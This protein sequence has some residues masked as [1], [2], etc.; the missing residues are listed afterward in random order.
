[1]S[2]LPFEKFSQ[3]IVIKKES[4]TSNEYGFNY[5]ERPLRK[6]LDYS[7]VVINK[8]KGPS[9]HQISDYLKKILNA[10]KAGHSGTLDPGVTGCLPIT[11]N[12]ATRIVQTL[13][14]SGKEYI[15]LMHLHNKIPQSKIHQ[16]FKKQ[17]GKIQQVPPIKS[18]VKRV[19]RTREI[20][21]IEI[22]EIENQEV[23]F[24]VGCEAGT[25]IRKLCHDIGQELKTG[26]HMAQLVRTKAGPFNF[27]NSHS[28]Y[29]IKD[30]FESKNESE[31]R[32]FLL[33]F[34][35][36]VKYFPKIWITDTTVNPLCHGADLAIPGISK[37]H[38]KIKKE[39]LV[40]IM[41]LKDE[42]V[43]LGTSKMASKDIL[44]KQKGIAVKTSK[45]FMDRN[46]YPTQQSS[47]S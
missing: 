5:K 4:I 40:A 17:L 2:K 14:K 29:E 33:P 19:K 15:C 18:A 22:L 36:A 16:A 27:E 7:L 46:I 13:L 6:L 9:S 8:P 20:Y 32:K 37:L 23:L 39:D 11:L 26:A 24:K 25:Y 42:L 31:I 28:L 10:K 44:E 30:V 41:S 1:M 3:K 38:D 47:N 34:E 21:Y 12:K 45:V 43:C 35:E